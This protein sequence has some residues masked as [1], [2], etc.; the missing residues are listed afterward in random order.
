VDTGFH[1]AHHVRV[2]SRLRHV[3]GLVVVIL[4]SA[5]PWLVGEPSLTSASCMTG[6]FPTAIVS[7]V[8]VSTS[9]VPDWGV[10]VA[11]QTD[12]GSTRS[13]LFSGRNPNN[14]LP[15]GSENTFEDA[16]SGA[17]PEVGGQY[18][19]SGAEF[20]GSGGPLGVSNCAESAS[21][22]VLSSPPTETTVGAP[23]CASST[24]SSS[25]AVMAV[26][27][28][29]SVLGLG[30]LVIILRRKAPSPSP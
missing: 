24:S 30:T 8:V 7:G 17:L 5:V 9:I 12:D 27:V 22:K 28:A 3:P 29:G 26:L 15:D 6:A 23:Q 13:V 25:R 11:V 21:V 14:I 20:E 1:L 4:A 19:I 10:F 2:M 16:W 18:T